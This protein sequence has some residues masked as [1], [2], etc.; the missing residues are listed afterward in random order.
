M[1]FC[2]TYSDLQ[3]TITSGELLNNTIPFTITINLAKVNTAWSQEKT[4]GFLK[5]S[6]VQICCLVQT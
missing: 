2:N 5:S 1:N 6:S 3:N 4:S